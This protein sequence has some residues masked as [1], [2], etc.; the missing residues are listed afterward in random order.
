[1]AQNCD[2]LKEQAHYATGVADLA[3][4][5]RDAAEAFLAEA[6][7]AL[8]EMVTAHS[9]KNIGIDASMRRTRANKRAR[10]VLAKRTDELAP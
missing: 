7:D 2:D 9:M 10:E 1:M 3:M 5:H 6:L 8:Q 4:K